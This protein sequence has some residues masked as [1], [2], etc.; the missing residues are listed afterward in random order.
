MHEKLIN[1]ESE[2][3]LRKFFF[4]VVCVEVEF[5]EGWKNYCEEIF[6]WKKF[7]EILSI[8]VLRVTGM[9]GQGIERFPGAGKL[10]RLLIGR[11]V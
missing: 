9:E 5:V 7:L 4:F 3:E 1:R 11:V 8:I 6:S 2:E 10:V